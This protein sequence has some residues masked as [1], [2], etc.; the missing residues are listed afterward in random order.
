MHASQAYIHRLSSDCSS[1]CA[2]RDESCVCALNSNLQASG[3]NGP[4]P[5]ATEQKTQGNVATV[6]RH[7]FIGKLPQARSHEI[8]CCVLS[9]VC[10]VFPY[11]L[12]H[13]RKQPGPEPI[14]K[15][16]LLSTVRH[17]LIYIVSLIIWI[18]L[19]WPC[20]A[21]GTREETQKHSYTKQ[22]CCS[23]RSN[24]HTCGS[25]SLEQHEASTTT[26]HHTDTYEKD[27]NIHGKE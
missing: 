26:S 24:R 5:R 3:Q 1:R 23:R 2:W 4:E 12:Q 27:R 25:S 11:S 14:Q 8:K 7:L 15:A 9:Y 22:G 17:D 20:A 16:T 18:H 6:R 19:V 21:K 13:L 10:H